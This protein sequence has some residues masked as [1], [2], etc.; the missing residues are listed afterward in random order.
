MSDRIPCAA[1]NCEAKVH[2]RGL[3]GPHYNRWKRSR[4]PHA[5]PLLN[6]SGNI[7][8]RFMSRVDKTKSGCWLWT[9]THSANGYGQFHFNGARYPAHVWAYERLVGPVPDGLQLDHLCH[10]SDSSCTGG[11]IC[12]HRRCVNPS[13]LEPVTAR[14]NTLRGNSLQAANAAKTHCSKGHPFDAENTHYTAR[15]R[16]VCRACQRAFTASYRARKKIGM[17]DLS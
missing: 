8:E 9:S 15:G 2:A 3:C 14:E 10:T 7:D 16:R 6:L 13:H 17:G 4:D 11:V 12:L 1:D 5:E